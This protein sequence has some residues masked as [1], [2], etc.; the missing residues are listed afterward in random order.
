MCFYSAVVAYVAFAAV[1]PV[2]D[3]GLPQNGWVLA[4][5][6]ILRVD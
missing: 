2:F 6:V 3:V 1:G 5:Y 4:G